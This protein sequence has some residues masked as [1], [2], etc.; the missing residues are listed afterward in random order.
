MD[1]PLQ[2]LTPDELE[3][4]MKAMPEG[5]IVKFDKD[6]NFETI[7]SGGKIEDRIHEW[8][9]MEGFIHIVGMGMRIGTDYFCNHLEENYFPPMTPANDEYGFAVVQWN[10]LKWFICTIP[11]DKMPCA[12]ESAAAANL[13]IQDAVPFMVGPIV[14]S[15]RPEHLDDEAKEKFGGDLDWFP[16]NTSATYTLEGTK[17]SRVYD[18]PGARQDLSVETELKR[19]QLYKKKRDERGKDSGT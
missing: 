6:A 14:A 7:I 17:E 16:L 19:Q 8:A 3:M 13:K 9:E 10:N 12:K 1:D 15:T 11:A 4:F 18:G 5:C 2:G